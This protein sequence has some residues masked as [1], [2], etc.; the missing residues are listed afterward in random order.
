MIMLLNIWQCNIKKNTRSKFLTIV[1][2]TGT[3]AA[4]SPSSFITGVNAAQ[5]G[6]DV[7]AYFERHITQSQLKSYQRN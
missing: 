3:F 4:I 5:C 7:K 2:I 1:L 6:G